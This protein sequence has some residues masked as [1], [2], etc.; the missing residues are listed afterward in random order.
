MQNARFV[1]LLVFRDLNDQFGDTIG[2]NRC[3]RCGIAEVTIH[4]I[5]TS[6]E[7]KEDVCPECFN[8]IPGERYS[9]GFEIIRGPRCNVCHVYDAGISIR[10]F[11]RTG[12][13]QRYVCGLTCAFEMMRGDRKEDSWAYQTSKRDEGHKKFRYGF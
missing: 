11:T 7:E 10:R 4:S 8:G 5:R 6:P 13:Q 2:I 12:I 9:A 1:K 3:H